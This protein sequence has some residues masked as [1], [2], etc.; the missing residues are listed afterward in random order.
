MFPLNWSFPCSIFFYGSIQCSRSTGSE[1]LV[2]AVF[3]EESGS[4]DM[5][6][7]RERSEYKKTLSCSC[8]G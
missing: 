5:M 8:D 6:K 7:D 3:I 2:R 1:G 4:L